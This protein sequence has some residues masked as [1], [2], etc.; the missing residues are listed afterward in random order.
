MLAALLVEPGRIVVDEVAEPDVGPD[1]VRIAVGGVGLCGSDLS[2]FSGK[3]TAP[4]YPWIM[5]HEAF[6]TIEAVGADVERARLG[7]LVVIEPNVACRDCFECGRGRT[8]GCRRRQS[9]GMNRPG[10]LAEMVVVPADRAWPM[11]A[12]EPRDLVCV[13]PFTVVETALRRLP[14]EL[15]EEALVVGVGAQGLL[16]TLALARRGVRAWVRDV[17]PERVAFAT[18]RLGA[19]ALDPGDDRQFDLIVDTTGVPEAVAEAVSR[20][21]VGATIVELGLEKREFQLNAETLVRRQVVL[22]GSLT[23]DHPGDFEW[24]TALVSDGNIAPG[25]VI[26]H[27]HPFAGAQEA[28]ESSVR[29]PGK[30]WIRSAQS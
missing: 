5:G 7:E 3:W 2:V 25:R 17:N 27:E 23:Y 12:I 8:S 14:G 9:V 20:S 1:E 24:S 11:A 28:F 30:T 26:S 10:A 29:A 18:E 16:M 19:V 4:R 22:L 6:G 15:P 21:Q 13:E